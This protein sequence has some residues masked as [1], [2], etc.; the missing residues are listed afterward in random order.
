M[1]LLQACNST[2]QVLVKP[3]YSMKYDIITNQNAVRLTV[4]MVNTESN[5]AFDYTVEDNIS[6]SVKCVSSAVRSSNELFHSFNGINKVLES[7]TSLRISD[8]TFTEILNG[9]PT[10]LSYR[11]G[12]VKNTLKY[13][14]VEKQK[15]KYLINGKLKVVEVLYVEDTSKKGH[16]LWIW[17]NP[18]TPLILRLKFGYELVLKEIVTLN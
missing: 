12:F 4:K 7:G 15:H 17:N 10:E 11:L 3:G 8:S 18:S 2:K 9:T 5:W 16:A 14:L 1:V 13:K 6:G